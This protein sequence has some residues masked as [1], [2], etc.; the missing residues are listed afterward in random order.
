MPRPVSWSVRTASSSRL[1]SRTLIPRR[2]ITAII[3]AAQRT[4]VSP[5]V[6]LKYCIAKR[7]IITAAKKAGTISSRQP[8][9]R[10]SRRIVA[11]P[12]CQAAA[13]MKAAE[14]R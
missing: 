14:I 1:F 5:P 6:W 11:A 10:A 3:V 13:P 7:A 2:V 9:K 4:V 8:S 12:C